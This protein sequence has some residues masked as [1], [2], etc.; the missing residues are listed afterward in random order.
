MKVRIKKHNKDGFIRLET[1]GKIEEIM[2][3]EDFM[4]PRSESI[5]LCF[6]G[7]N[8]SGIIDLTP[9]EIEKLYRTLNARSHL[10]KGVK[11]IKG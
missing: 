3:N 4:N 9:A 8:S 11:V 2:I 5:A 1:I 10:I 7:S 6:K